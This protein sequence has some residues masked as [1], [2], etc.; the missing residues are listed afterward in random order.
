MLV[1]WQTEIESALSLAQDEGQI[2]K[3]HDPK[4]ISQYVIAN[5]GGVRYL[6]KVLGK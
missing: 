5:Y 6:G 2:A 3:E 4:Q 1:A